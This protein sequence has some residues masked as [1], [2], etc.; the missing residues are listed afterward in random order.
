MAPFARSPT[1][2]IAL[3]ALLF[4]LVRSPLHFCARA[5]PVSSPLVSLTAAATAHDSSWFGGEGPQ[6]L[7]KD[8]DIGMFVC[9]YRCVRVCV[10]RAR[11]CV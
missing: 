7:K 10:A 2:A 5:A 1:L 3:V 6:P 11:V 9:G 4:S 8:F